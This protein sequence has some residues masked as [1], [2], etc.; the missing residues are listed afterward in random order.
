MN[1]FSYLC[2]TFRN[3]N[4]RERIYQ[5][6][7]DKGY[8]QS[9]FANELC[10]APATLSSIFN[11][12]TKP[13]N[14]VVNA[15]HEAFPDVNISWLMFGDGSPY[16]SSSAASADPSAAA[17]SAG[18]S[19]GVTPSAPDSSSFPESLF[20]LAGTAPSAAASGASTVPAGSVNVDGQSSAAG[21]PSLMPQQRMQVQYIEK[22]IDKPQRKITEIRVF[23]DDGTYET[24]PR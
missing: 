23:F 10:L 2:T 16:L 20:D 8:T 14:N 1:R 15:I 3:T 18:S 19:S 5:L 7:K 13:T 17:S 22:I 6:M 11:G 12:R 9:D 24:F 21:Q 4:M